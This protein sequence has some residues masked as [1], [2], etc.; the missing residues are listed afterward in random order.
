MQCVG[1][2]KTAVPLRRVLPCY[3][4]FCVA[5]GVAGSVGVAVLVGVAV[6][7]GVSG[8]GVGVV[9]AQGSRVKLR[10]RPG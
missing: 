10:R 3:P 2:E 4:D 6:G 8:V 5:G 9:V 1:M 7:N